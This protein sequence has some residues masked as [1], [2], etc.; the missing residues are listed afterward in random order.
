LFLNEINADD[1]RPFRST[2]ITPGFLW[3]SCCSIF[4]V[5][6]SSLFIVFVSFFWPLY[7]LSV[8]CLRSLFSL[9]GIFNLCDQIQ[10]RK[11]YVM[12]LLDYSFWSYNP[13]LRTSLKTNRRSCSINMLIPVLIYIDKNSILVSL[14]AGFVKIIV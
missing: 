2:W 3:A 7:C 5:F 6:C 1:V 10:N 13:I 14:L 11:R 12:K 9:F 8:V 4:A